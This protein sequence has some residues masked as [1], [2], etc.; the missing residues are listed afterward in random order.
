M[1]EKYGY[2]F[3]SDGTD[4]IA[5][6]HRKPLGEPAKNVIRGSKYQGI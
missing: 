5:T 4:S 1:G 6:N 2:L 3:A